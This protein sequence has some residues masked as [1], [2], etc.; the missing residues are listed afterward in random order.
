MRA[1]RYGVTLPP[2]FD[3]WFFKATAPNPAHR[4]ARAS[5][6]VLGLAE[7][8]GVKLDTRPMTSS[9]ADWEIDSLS[10]SRTGV[11]RLAGGL[12][13]PAMPSA[14]GSVARRRRARPGTGRRC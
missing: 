10:L 14:P 13:K 11:M 7:A 4:Y 9:G 12:L 3:P 8:L 5:D 2:A 6:L 1:K